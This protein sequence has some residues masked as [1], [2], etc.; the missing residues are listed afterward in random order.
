MMIRR[1]VQ[2]AAAQL[3]GRESFSYLKLKESRKSLLTRSFEE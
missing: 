2:T 3:Q 1:Q